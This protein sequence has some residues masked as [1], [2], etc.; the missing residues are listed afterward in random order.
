MRMADRISRL[1]GMGLIS[2]AFASELAAQ[3]APTN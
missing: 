1:V 3:S 2:L